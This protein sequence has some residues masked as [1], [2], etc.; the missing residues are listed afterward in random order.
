MRPVSPIVHAFR[1]R[2]AVA[3]LGLAAAVP[4][5][6]HAQMPTVEWS[7]ADAKALI[8]LIEAADEEG[9]DPRDYGP[10]MLRQAV[11]RDMPSSTIFMESALRLANDY[12]YGRV[13]AADRVDWFA[14]EAPNPLLLTQIIAQAVA[15]DRLEEAFEQLLP[16]HDDYR[17]LKRALA[18]T[19]TADAQRRMTLRINLE[20]WRWMPRELGDKHVFVNIPSYRIELVDG[21]GLVTEHA[22]IVGK[23]TTPTPSFSAEIKAVRFNPPW[24]VPPGLKKQK[25]S[26][27]KRNPAAARRLGYSVAYT[28]DGVSIWQR[29]GPGNALGKVKIDMP[30]PHAIYLHD[31]PSKH[32]FGESSRAFSHGCIRVKDVERLAAEL[33]ERDAGDAAAVRQALAGSATRTLTL[34]KARPV[35]LVYFT[36]DAAPDGAIVRYEDPYG[37]DAKLIASLDRPVLHARRVTAAVAATGS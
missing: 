5:S 37:R 35:Y 15:E 7:K 29:P 8:G 1:R 16:R 9:L 21:G 10:E 23:P 4:T 26:L 22:A 33:A 3:L 17:A 6:A 30:N 36:L 12:R 24:A 20:R 18:E 31:T 27:Y 34:P 19:P 14:G 11:M 28:P 32:L 25:L 13:P 2:A